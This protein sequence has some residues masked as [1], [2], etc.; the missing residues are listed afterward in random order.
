M[1]SSIFTE[2]VLAKE[3]KNFF[4]IYSI[5]PNQTKL[6]ELCDASVNKIKKDIISFFGCEDY[7]LHLFTE[8]FSNSFFPSSLK[9]IKEFIQSN[10]NQLI[11]KLA[12]SKIPDNNKEKL[13]VLLEEMKEILKS[14][15]KY[16]L[17][18]T[19]PSGK[20]F[21]RWIISLSRLCNT[22]FV[23]ED[24]TAYD[25]PI[26]FYNK[27][28]K[29]LPVM[30]QQNTNF[31]VFIQNFYS[32]LA[33]IKNATYNMYLSFHPMDI[34]NV[35]TGRI[36]SCNSPDGMYAV[37]PTTVLN[38][39]L[40]GVLVMINNITK[41]RIGRCYISFSSDLKGFLC[42]PTYGNLSS[43]QV[44]Q[45]AK[46]IM[47]Y[48][49]YALKDDKKWFSVQNTE[50]INRSALEL[51]KGFISTFS[52]DISSHVF[53]RSDAQITPH[54]ELGNSVCLVCGSPGEELVCRKCINKL[55]LNK[56]PTC[57]RYKHQSKSM[58]EVCS[59]NAKPC[60]VCGKLTANK[61]SICQICIHTMS[62][63][64]CL[65]CGGGLTLYLDKEQIKFEDIKEH[66]VNYKKHNQPKYEPRR[67]IELMPDTLY[68]H[69]RCLIKPAK[70]ANCGINFIERS[71]Y[72][73]NTLCVDCSSTAYYKKLLRDAKYAIRAVDKLRGSKE[74]ELS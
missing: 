18:N 62:R 15:D 28:W 41:E 2:E 64:T 60:K 37:A 1:G 16:C 21:S 39:E 9:T 42:Q 4:D 20:K 59:K 57:N 32:E 53:V 61:N 3:Y 51:S 52:I 44:V 33:K 45:A 14:C 46:L 74:I 71:P 30:P 56:C 55:Q 22:N 24:T 19:T 43:A 27:A 35:S 26:I 34:L 70:C 5:T 11:N 73:G 40:T 48:I 54:I 6:A 58:C 12:Q 13:T 7:K 36:R 49:N 23:T 66:I 17:E 25:Y 50:D 72:D 63:Q 69:Y 47:S 10:K 65:I 67:P 8:T 38:S 29:E 31:E 68:A